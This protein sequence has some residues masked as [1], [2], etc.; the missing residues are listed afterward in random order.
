MDIK[1]KRKELL[2]MDDRAFVDRILAFPDRERLNRDEDGNRRKYPSAEMAVR[3]RRSMEKDPGYKISDKQKYVMADSF[4]Q[5]S[6]NELKVAGIKFAKA[7]PD[8]LVKEEMS[9]EGVKTVYNM[10]FLLK[11]EPENEHDRNAVAVYVGNTTGENQGMTKIG[12]VP[13][14][15]V[16]QHPIVRPMSVKGTLTDHSNGHFKT[17]S[18]TMDL[19]TEAL[20]KETA[21]DRNPRAYTY[22][23]PFILNG[24]AKEGAADYLNRQRDWAGQ[25]NSEFEYWGVNGQADKVYFEFPGA[26]AGSIIVE[27][28]QKLSSEA[29]QVSGSYLGY[30]L[31]TGISSDLKRDGYV[32]VPI[33]KPAVNTREKTYF[34]LQAEPKEP[35]NAHKEPEKSPQ[36]R[37]IELHDELVPPFDKADT[38]AGELV[39]ATAKIAERYYNDGDQIGV[40]YGNRTCNAPARFLFEK[41]SGTEAEGIIRNMWGMYDEDTY[42]I[43]L[44]KLMGA[45]ADYIEENPGLK[46]ERNTED[47]LDRFDAFEDRD[48]SHDEEEDEYYEDEDDYEDDEDEDFEDAVGALGDDDGPKR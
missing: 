18:Y 23:M 38:K 44:N 39:R 17:I 3:V 35:E 28:Q 8:T 32:D 29:M 33:Q 14:A 2:R 26:K 5:Y 34:S 19:D 48:D 31:E 1:Q 21:A 24:D 37:I 41:L 16:A 10:D 22:R 46:T 40:G 6:T 45:V 12:Y 7:D 43:N 15:Y 13:G 47:M 30:C 25:L 20:D 42:K 11:P 36:E 9:K 27:S 4:A